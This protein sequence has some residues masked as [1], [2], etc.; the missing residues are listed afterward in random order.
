MGA[1]ESLNVAKLGRA[2]DDLFG[3]LGVRPTHLPEPAPNTVNCRPALLAIWMI[4]RPKADRR[5]VH[6]QVPIALLIDPTGHQ[7]QIRTT[8]FSWQPLH[9]G[10]V[11]LPQRY[12]NAAT[13]TGIDPG[14]FIKES[15]EHAIASHPDTLLLT[16]A[17]NLRSTWPALAGPQMDV[18]TIDLGRGPQP[19]KELPGLRHIWVRSAHG[20]GTPQSYGVNDGIIGHPK[21]MWRFPE[22]RLFASTS[23]KPAYAVNSVLRNSKIAEGLPYGRDGFTRLNTQA[24]VWNEQLL[25]LGVA[26]LQNGDQPE[27]WAAMAHNLRDAVPYTRWTTPLPWPLQLAQQIEEQVQP[28]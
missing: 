3:Q 26:G 13:A 18:D 9:V 7:V 11:D 12:G 2:V 27:Q 17:Q 23:G 15:V 22:P 24:P 5:R 19:I 16:H 1:P 10:L 6:R 8:W 4:R 14:Q 25:E 21:G 20:A 28:R